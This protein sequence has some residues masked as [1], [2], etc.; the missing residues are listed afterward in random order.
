MA[1]AL[2][3]VVGAVIAAGAAIAVYEAVDGGSA[4]TARPPVVA[5]Q[6]AAPANGQTAQVVA[7]KA[8]AHFDKVPITADDYVLGK[9]DAPVTVVEYAS[10]TCPHCARMSNDAIAKFEKE[11]VETGKARYVYRDFPLD[12]IAVRASVL[13]R[14]NGKERY[15]PFVKALF[16]D[17]MNWI[18]SPDPVKALEQVGRL[19]GVSPQK[20]ESC[21]KDQSLVDKVLQSRLEGQKQYNI[22][23]TPTFIVNGD[24]YSGEMSYPQFRAIIAAHMPKG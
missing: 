21:L 23:S 13:A 9:A 16:A 3:Y 18:R 24:K 10:M 11:F 8:E 14:C 17:Q 7:P 12:Q 2:P 22:D 15:F 4:Q 20:F 1:N 6:P 19:G 5:E